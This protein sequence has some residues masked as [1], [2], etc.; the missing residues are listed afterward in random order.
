MTKI[1]GLLA[2]DFAG[3]SLSRYLF[4]LENSLRWD[5][6]PLPETIG[7]RTKPWKSWGEMGVP[8]HVGFKVSN[9][10]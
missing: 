3:S 8:S 9:R 6:V 4:A 2:V 10:K 7:N 5:V 1:W